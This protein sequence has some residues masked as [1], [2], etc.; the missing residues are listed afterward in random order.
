M[1]SYLSTPLFGF[2]R[3]LSRKPRASYSVTFGSIFDTFGGL[4]QLTKDVVP[5]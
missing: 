4:D 5:R 1:V 2:I 3:K